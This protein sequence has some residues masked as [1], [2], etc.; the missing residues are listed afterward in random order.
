M[1]ERSCSALPAVQ[2]LL[3]TRTW[4]F[5]GIF[6]V[7]YLHATVVA[8]LALFNPVMCHGF[9][10]LLLAGFGPCV[11]REPVWGHFRLEFS[12]SMYLPEKQ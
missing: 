3:F 11:V 10:C 1:N 6:Y 12:Q 8:D 9:L 5:M 4:H 2:C 7:C